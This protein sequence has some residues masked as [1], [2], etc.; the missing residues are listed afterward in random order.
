MNRLLELSSAR[1]IRRRRTS[2][3]SMNLSI[4]RKL[5]FDDERSKIWLDGVKLETRKRKWKAI[6]EDYFK[7]RISTLIQAELWKILISFKPK[8]E[9]LKGFALRIYTHLLLRV[10]P[11]SS[12]S[13]IEF[14]NQFRLFVTIFLSV[15]LHSWKVLKLRS[16]LFTYFSLFLQTIHLFV[17]RRH[18]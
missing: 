18:L 3:T 8:K 7:N 10:C 1:R 16:T 15:F 4:M 13:T 17:R 5:S 12:V 14:K 11:D 6:K 9:F 2:C